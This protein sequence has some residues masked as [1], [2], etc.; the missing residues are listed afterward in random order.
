MQNFIMSCRVREGV[1]DSW[2][3]NMEM[4]NDKVEIDPFGSLGW[5]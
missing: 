1:C 2:I 3:S 5:I 4:E